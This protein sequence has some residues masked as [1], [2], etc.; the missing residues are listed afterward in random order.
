MARTGPVDFQYHQAFPHFSTSLQAF[1]TVG[2]CPCAFSSILYCYD[3]TMEDAGKGWCVQ[4]SVQ[5]LMPCLA[6]E[7]H[8]SPLAYS[9]HASEQSAVGLYKPLSGLDCFVLGDNHMHS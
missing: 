4:G 2:Q 9:A 3:W 1:V 7:S 8:Y 5:F 6:G